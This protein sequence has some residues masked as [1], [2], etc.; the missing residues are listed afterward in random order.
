M[1]SV[2]RKA[3]FRDFRRLCKL[4]RICFKSGFGREQIQSLL[5]NSNAFTIVF[6]DGKRILGSLI[7]YADGGSARILTLSVHPTFRRRGIG[8]RLMLE[9]ELVIQFLKLPKVV[10][11]VSTKNSPAVAL[12]RSLGYQLDGIIENYYAWE[13]DAYSMSK[14]IR[15]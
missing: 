6:E 3:T 5:L 9:A 11:E 12:Y 4:E 7:L 14:D 10:L 8:R 13:D 1:I 15:R 2:I